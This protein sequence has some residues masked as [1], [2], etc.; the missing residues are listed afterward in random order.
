MK[1]Y[2]FYKKGVTELSISDD[3]DFFNG[4]GENGVPLRP[5]QDKSSNEPTDWDIYRRQWDVVDSLLE[6][7]EKN[8]DYQNIANLIKWKDDELKT[9]YEG[10]HYTYIKKGL[11]PIRKIVEELNKDKYESLSLKKKRNTKEI[12]DYLYKNANKDST[13]IVNIL[14]DN[15]QY[16]KVVQKLNII[17]DEYSDILAAVK[18]FD[19]L[20][21]NDQNAV[22]KNLVSFRELAKRKAKLEK[23]LK[24]IE[25]SIDTSS[26]GNALS[27]KQ[28]KSFYESFKS[29][30]NHLSEIASEY[31]VA[32]ALSDTKSLGQALGEQG[33]RILN[34]GNIMYRKEG[35]K[36]STIKLPFD[37][38]IINE[39]NKNIKLKLTIDGKKDNKTLGELYDF[40]SKVEEHNGIIHEYKIVIENYDYLMESRAL[41]GYTIQTKFR[42]NTSSISNINKG[43]SYTINQ[44]INNAQTDYTKDRNKIIEYAKNLELMVQWYKASA[45]KYPNPP[46]SSYPGIVYATYSPDKPATALYN[47][48]F[49]YILSR[50][51]VIEKI[52]GPS[53]FFFATMGG[54]ITLNDYFVNNIKCTV[55]PGSHSA[56]PLFS[57]LRPNRPVDLKLAGSRR[58]SL[59]PATSIRAY[60]GKK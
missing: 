54:T 24:I 39:H 26:M 3:W 4:R 14:N 11:A 37:Q 25:D 40:L 1:P 10:D 6:K 8:P 18:Y 36:K 57:I 59:E 58:I 19:N 9:I 27:Y 50:E 43:N 53:V 22:G 33:M 46:E 5:L 41:H 13:A 7:V 45:K 42:Q 56:N 12:N 52:Y 20:I 31:T 16:N 21:K 32:Y 2:E 55:N 28:L 38:I 51:E 48:Y 49:N 47:Q 35:K 29:V 44:A 23:N 60:S 15:I 30:S 34:V 17:M